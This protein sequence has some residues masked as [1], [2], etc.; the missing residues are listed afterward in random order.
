MKS[1][2]DPLN[3]AEFK[4]R[5]GDSFPAVYLTLISII[6]GVAM[7]ILASNTFMYIKDTNLAEPWVR[8]LPYSTMSF[9]LLIVVTY[10]YTWFVGVFKWSPKIWDTIIPF[11]LGLSEIGPMFY[12][13]NPCTWWLLTAIFCCVGAGG[14]FN[15]LWNCKQFM[16][17]ENEK[18]YR[19]TRNT[20]RWI[21][22]LLS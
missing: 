20:L 11:A 21:Y 12:L 19:R 10:E 1:V 7:G 15:T 14:F 16:F 8:F 17:G 4:R 2:F 9:I 5:I 18:A 22:L 3:T 13:T 6:Q